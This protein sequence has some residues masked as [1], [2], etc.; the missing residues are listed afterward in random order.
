VNAHE[1][2]DSEVEQITQIVRGKFE[3]EADW[4][5]SSAERRSG[6]RDVVDLHIQNDID[7]RQLIVPLTYEDFP[8]GNFPNQSQ[9][10]DAVFDISISLME[11]RHIRGFDEF[12][13]GAAVPILEIYPEGRNP[14]FD[15][16]LPLPPGHRNNLVSPFQTEQRRDESK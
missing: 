16:L 8:G 4:S 7:H 6:Q 15:D 9:L 1:F 2:S 13:D 3:Q 5:L 14:L 11:F 10:T 12:E